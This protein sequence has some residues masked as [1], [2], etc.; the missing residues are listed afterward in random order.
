MLFQGPARRDQPLGDHLLLRMEA[1]R[2]H[3]HGNRHVVAEKVAHDHAGR[4]DPERMLLAIERH[5]GFARGLELLEQ[6][7]EPGDGVRR[8]PLETRA[9]QPRDRHLV[10]LGEIGLAVGGAIER[11]RLADGRHRAQPVRPDHLIDEDEVILLDGG[12]IDGFVEL[13]GEPDQERTRQGHEIGARGGGKP[14]DGGA[15]AHPPRRGRCNQELFRRER[16]DDA[17]HGRAGERDALRDLPKAQA[18]G[19][20]LERAQDRRSAGDDLDLALVL[21]PR[22]TRRLGRLAADAALVV[23]AARPAPL[24]HVGRSQLPI[25]ATGPTGRA[26]RNLLAGSPIDTLQPE[27]GTENRGGEQP[28]TAWSGRS[29]SKSTASLPAS[30]IIGRR[31]LSTCRRR[32]G[33]T[34]SRASPTSA[35]CGS[36]PWTGPASNAACFRWPGQACRPN[37]TRRP[38][39][40]GRARRTTSWPAK[41]PNAPT[42][43]PALLILPC[44]T[45]APRRTSSNAAC[46]S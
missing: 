46:G 11:K 23:V 40:A 21:R 22:L 4:A 34:S 20:L 2:R 27:Y 3:R 42:A 30:R 14:Q 6:F 8:A 26:R 10:E 39:A 18:R 19:L 37:A 12:E 28:R 7:V 35:R 38:R 25:K 36:L 29:R 45:P 15:E 33:M 16:G 5:P 31:R 9:D 43:I 32:S 41:S 17:L 44:R 24:L 1:L 13:V